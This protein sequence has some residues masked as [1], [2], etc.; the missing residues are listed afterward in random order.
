MPSPVPTRTN[1]TV[2][3]VH[4]DI[5]PSNL[6]LTATGQVKI[7]DLGLALLHCSEPT[8]AELTSAGQVMGTP[9]YLSPEQALETH[10]VDIR[11]DIYS[12][13]CTLFKLLTGHSPFHGEAYDTPF[14]KITG[15]ARDLAPP[16]AKF[17]SD[18]PEAVAASVRRM[19]AKEPADRFS[20]PVDVAAALASY[21][22]ESDLPT[23]LEQAQTSRNNIESP[24]APAGETPPVRSSAVADT[25]REAA[26]ERGRRGRGKG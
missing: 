5:K 3:L 16:V 7:L 14:K 1:S 2:I 4:R 15:H 25:P 22:T 11:T 10:S 13:G 12:L 23:L 20:V 19:L 17:R 6:M 21:C 24:S 9:D 18:V 26:F 8:A